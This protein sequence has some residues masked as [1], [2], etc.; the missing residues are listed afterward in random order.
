MRILKE[1]CGQS[2]VLVALFMGIVMLGFLAFAIDGGYLFYQ[3]RMVQAAADAA[4]VAAAEEDSYSGDSGNAQAAA[5]AAAQMNGF[6]TTAATN[7]ATVTLTTLGSGTYSNSGSD[8]A[9]TIWVQAVVSQPVPT[10][11][12][13]GF[14]RNMKTM[15]VSATAVAGGGQASPTCVCLEG[16]TGQ[17]LNMSNNATL[18]TSSCGVAVNSTSSNAVGVIGSASITSPTLGIVSTSWTESSNVS[19]GGSIAS[20][21][22]IVQGAPNACSPAMPTAP[23]YS[24]CVADPGGAFGTF[25]FGPASSSGTVCYD[26]LT[27]GANS[28][29]V[30]LN[31]GTYV[32]SSGVLHFES[33]TGGRSNLGGNG[34]FF[35]LTGTASLVI[36]NGANVN[37]VA[38]AATESG[39]GTA[40]NV[41][42]YN[43]ILIYQASSD[44]TAISVQG[45]ATAFLSGAI[46][47]PSAAITLGNGSGTTFNSDIV[48]QSL[49]M[50]GGGILS[51]TPS[52]SLGSFGAGVAKLTQ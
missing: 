37:L 29:T 11:F 9:P 27:V 2:V 45:G 40:P 18:N 25:T 52:A 49:T 24:G 33:G 42:S 4:A 36:D 46:L 50:N 13:A 23:T 30:T 35:Y 6:S 16:G 28:A 15:T 1:E 51:S 5:N 48:A 20:S 47:A 34:V 38:G 7:P 19:N 21:T 41:G 32:I 44:A 3:K 10:F 26:G 31:P 39:G 43:G 8:P 17:D 12:L 14:N 22:K